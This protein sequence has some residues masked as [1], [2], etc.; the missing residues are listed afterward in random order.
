MKAASIEQKNINFILLIASITSIIS[1]FLLAP[2]RY[3]FASDQF[4]TEY[5]VLYDIKPSGETQITQ[6]IKIINKLPDVVATSYSLNI[7]KMNIYDIVGKDEEGNLEIQT[8]KVG[9]TIKISTKFN[10]QIIG[11]GRSLDWVL[12]Y[13]SKDIATKVGDIWNISIPKVETLDTTKNYRVTLKIPI[14]FGPEI[15]VSPKPSKKNPTNTFYELEFT[16]DAL[17]TS[18]ITTSHGK[19]QIFN[20]KLGFAL[21]NNSVFSTFQE[22]ALPPDIKGVQQVRYTEINPLPFSF[23]ED[24]DGNFI[25][26][27][28]VPPKEKIHIVATGSVSLKGSQINP[29][30][31]GNIKDIPANLTRDYTKEQ[32]YWEISAQPIQK[33]A[34][35]LLKPELTVV[36]NAQS[37]Y[38][39]VTKTLKYDFGVSQKE[40]IERNGA[41]AAVLQPGPW[42]CMEFTDLF[43][44]L[45]RA[46]GIPA[47]E[48]DGFAYTRESNLTPL[49]ISL[50][51]GDLLHSWAEFYDPNFGWVQVDPTWGNTSGI[52]Y[53][54]K[55]D[56]S[57]FAFSI[58][59]MDSEYP[60]PAGSYKVDGTEKQV[61]VDIAQNNFLTGFPTNLQVFKT[62]NLNP[63]NLFSKKQTYIVFNDGGVK[64]SNFN[65]TGDKLLPKDIT[66]ITLPKDSREIYYEDANGD[67]Q[68]YRFSINENKPIVKQTDWLIIVL[69]VG[70]AIALCM[71]IYYLVTHSMDLQILHYRL[72]RRLRGQG[73]SPNQRLK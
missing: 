41:L 67:K 30:F 72:V 47:R 22:I 49:S 6:N 70:G 10:S 16:K 32:K 15:Y 24:K 13:K 68:F 11:T 18:G 4:D 3:T 36:Q 27:F 65:N 1:V 59:G 58:K 42:A 7:N 60:Y 8:E 66:Y 17:S 26:R 52:D 25:A 55:L 5:D 14:E 50:K 45:T 73:Q 19:N 2:Q 62:K 12:N 21:Q 56:T 46:M 57:H 34:K 64:L 63:I 35:N 44:A 29:D 54:T 40:F 20:F 38:N 71:I 69:S 43:I 51:N 31:G 61:E 23:F 9:E 48:V 37:V 33:V 53:F 28:K 39:Y